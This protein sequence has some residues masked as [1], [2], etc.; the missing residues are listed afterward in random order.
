MVGLNHLTVTFLGNSYP[1]NQ[2][3]TTLMVKYPHTVPTFA[4]LTKIL[5][6][7]SPCLFRQLQ[8]LHDLKPRK[9]IKTTI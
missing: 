3:S 2:P 9:S 6:V 5:L 7:K 4:G 8:K 1:H